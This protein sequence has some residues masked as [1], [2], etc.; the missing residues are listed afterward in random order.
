MKLEK[1]ELFR[2]GLYINKMV[3]I[4]NLQNLVNQ[5][6]P[7]LTPFNLTRIGAENDGGYLIPE[8]LDHIAACFSPG[9]AA[10]SSFELDLLSKK[11]IGSHLA[12]YSVEAAPINFEPLSFTK[13]FLGVYNDDI[14]MTLDTWVRSQKEYVLD[15]DFIL[16][17]DI[18][19]DEYLSLLGVSESVLT[20]FRIL[21]IEIHHIENWADPL[22][23]EIVTK[24]FNKILKYFYVVHN[25]PNNCCG[26]V[27]LGGFIAPRVF[28]LSFIRK[29]RCIP[30]GFCTTFPHEYDRANL[31]H[32][33]DL[34][35][36]A[37]WYA[38]PDQ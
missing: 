10:N 33:S 30:S 11:Q 6:R 12:D 5:L 38:A 34:H 35:L 36:P 3:S 32:R 18:E 24:F 29:D 1:Y 13:R 17:M 14:F 2:Q 22:F 27:D 19:G 20:R 4:E 15:A 7:V 25:H 28:E 31:K 37:H 9:V 23:F 26:L 21:A 16:Q 8:D